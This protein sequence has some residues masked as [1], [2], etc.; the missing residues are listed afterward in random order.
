MVNGE[1]LHGEYPNEDELIRMRQY[2]PSE[3]E[4]YVSEQLRSILEAEKEPT[5]QAK[6]ATDFAV[7]LLAEPTIYSLHSGHTEENPLLEEAPFRMD[8]PSFVYWC[9]HKAGVELRGGNLHHSIQTIKT[10]YQ[11]QTVGTI[12]SNLDYTDLA[13]GDIIFFYNDKHVGLYLEDG[14]FLSFIGSG[15]NN[16]SGGLRKN[17]MIIGK[18][19]HYFQGHVLRHREE[20]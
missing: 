16:H 15:A 4:T 7:S 17:N 8:S 1:P 12:G 9:Y 10:D 11:L 13:Y 14:D 6:E 3:K 18:W 5:E 2:I 20:V 19:R